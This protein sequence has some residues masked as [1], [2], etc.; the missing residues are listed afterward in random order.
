[1]VASSDLIV[2]FTPL[3]RSLA[4][5]Y[6][7]RSPL[8]YDDLYQIGV[9]AL[10]RAIDKYAPARSDASFPAFIKTVV[11]NA[12]SGER[13]RDARH[14]E[15]VADTLDNLPNG[16]DADGFPY[17]TRDS[18]ETLIEC[19]DERERQALRLFYVEGVPWKQIARIMETNV[20]KLR[21]LR[22]GAMNT[23]RRQLK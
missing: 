12:L 23:L 8:D 14:R 6:A 1:V 18:F 7:K 20:N 13:R 2:Q 22:E 19:L 17:V 11:R 10:L 4:G 9:V 5:K 3:L 21:I 16:H 15:H